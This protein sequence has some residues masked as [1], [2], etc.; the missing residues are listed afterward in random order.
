MTIEEYELMLDILEE[1]EK[2]NNNLEA[3]KKLIKAIVIDRD[4]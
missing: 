3:I 4:N 2:Y 1:I